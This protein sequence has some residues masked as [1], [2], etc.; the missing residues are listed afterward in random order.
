[1]FKMK[2]Y[3]QN[4][5]LKKLYDLQRTIIV[6]P[7]KFLT[8]KHLYATNFEKMNVRRAVKI[9]SPQ[10]TTALSY[11]EKYL[12]LIP[13][14]LESRPRIKLMEFIYTFFKI[15]D[16]SDFKIHDISDKTHYFRKQEPI[17]VPYVNINDERLTWLAETLLSYINT[18]QELSKQNKMK[19]LTKK[20]TKH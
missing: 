15:H 5:Y 17:S 20:N 2:L 19:G 16:V 14:F 10:V 3:R 8:K 1:M 4:K 13:D 6:K 9:F 7:V 18:L 11:L 12:I